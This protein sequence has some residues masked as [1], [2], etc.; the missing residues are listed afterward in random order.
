MSLVDATHTNQQ[1]LSPLEIEV[2]LLAHDLSTAKAE[3]AILLGDVQALARDARDAIEIY[4]AHQN[5]VAL[6]AAV[7]RL[8]AILRIEISRT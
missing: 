1:T 3:K 6:D 5:D 2:Q 7:E 4:R 8:D